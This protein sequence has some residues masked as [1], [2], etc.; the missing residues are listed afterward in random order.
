MSAKSLCP[1]RLMSK[2]PWCL[3]SSLHPEMP[4]FVVGQT[5]TSFSLVYLPTTLGPHPPAPPEDP[6][7]TTEGSGSI[8]PELD[9]FAMRPTDS[10]AITPPASAEEL[11]AAPV[12]A[13]TAASTT[14]TTTTAD[15]TDTTTTESSA[16]PT[17][18]IF[19][20]KVLSLSLCF[21]LHYEKEN[22]ALDDDDDDDDKQEINP[23][24]LSYRLFN[25]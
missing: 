20:G 16:A 8:A 7:A 3:F 24:P 23:V 22:V 13:P 10:S 4:F 14:I 2:S 15:N 6:F 1:H 17:L 5:N 12:P 19:G 21:S 11:A 18:D 9:L 25:S